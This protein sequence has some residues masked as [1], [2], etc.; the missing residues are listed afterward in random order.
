[1]SVLS[2]LDRLF[3]RERLDHSMEEEL[4]FHIAE[5]AADLQRS[6]L[7]LVEAERRAQLEF[8]GMENYKEQCRDT[9]RFHGIY[10]FFADIRFGFRILWRSPGFS[11]LAILCL[12]LGIGAN[13]AVFSWIEGILFRP[14]PAV[15][16][17]ERLFA[18]TGTARGETDPPSLSWPDFLDLQRSCTLVESFLV[19][20]ITGTTLSIGDR[21]EVT[22]GSIVSAHHFD[23]IAVHS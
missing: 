5:R 19:T 6:G 23:A 10:G 13:A 8:G 21:A 16:Q 9:R 17:Q 3:R 15:A 4:R 11:I 7:S 22:T 2:L 20:K 18:L 14:Y 1:M 12:T